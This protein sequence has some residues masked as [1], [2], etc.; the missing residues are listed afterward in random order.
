[1]R[2][3]SIFTHSAQAIAEGALISLLVVGLI[4]GTAF[5]AKPTGGSSAAGTCAAN[6][7]PVTLG[8]QYTIAGAG[9]KAGEVINVYI[10]DSL[11]TTVKSTAADGAGSWSVS[12]WASIA[13]TSNVDVRDMWGKH[14]ATRASCTFEVN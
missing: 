12:S 14:P 13:G 7:N 3:K 4:A 6:P 1:M 8:A 10:H 2:I 9:L 11:G 5:A